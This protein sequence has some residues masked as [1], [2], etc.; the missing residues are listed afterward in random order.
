MALT[1]PKRAVPLVRIVESWLC[2]SFCSRSSI[3]PPGEIGKSEP[4]SACDGPR[5]GAQSSVGTRVTLSPLFLGTHPPQGGYLIE[6][7][8]DETWRVSAGL[9]HAW[10]GNPGNSNKG[11]FAQSVDEP[12]RNNDPLSIEDCD[13]EPDFDEIDNMRIH[14]SLFYKLDRTSKEFEEY[15]FNFHRK[16]SPRRKEDPKEV[17][18]KEKENPSRNSPSKD[19][20]LHKVKNKLT[21]REE[22]HAYLLCESNELDGAKEEEEKK[23]RVP[24]F[25]ELT[26]PYHEP[27]CLDIFIS[28]ASVRACIV[29]RVTSKVVVV[30][31]SISKDMKF[32]LTSTRNARA[33]EAVGE[34]LAQRALADDIHDVVYTP[35]RGEVLGGKLGI[36]VQAI[37]KNG[38][39]VKLKLKQTR[40]KGQKRSHPS[41]CGAE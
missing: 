35:R 22:S 2:Q 9:A 18:E 16:K 32:D 14:G 7:V 31:H 1:Y 38:V 29:H 13:L 25:N 37:I 28:K 6:V 40:Q 39:N 10:H 15:N 20:K 27:F 24:T 5:K 41:L 21:R 19:E 30:A 23:S 36:V 33:C 34:V 8:D 26:G 11:K 4:G 17:K 3:F 12:E